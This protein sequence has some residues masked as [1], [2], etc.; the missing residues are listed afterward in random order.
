M[1]DVLL[2]DLGGRRP[3]CLGR[4]GTH[5]SLVLPCP[6]C[7]YPQVAA[8]IGQLQPASALTSVADGLAAFMTSSDEKVSHAAVSGALL[9]LEVGHTRPCVLVG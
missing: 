4:S 9:V 3:G 7:A 5:N 8:L 1:R 2:S 6:P